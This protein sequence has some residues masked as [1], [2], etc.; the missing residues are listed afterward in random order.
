MTEEPGGTRYLEGA[1]SRAGVCRYP[2]PRQPEVASPRSQQ[3]RWHRSPGTLWT[4]W[5]SLLTKGIR[6]K[7]TPL[8]QEAPSPRLGSRRQA[9]K[10]TPAPHP[11]SSPSG[12]LWPA[13]WGSD[14]HR[15]K[16]PQMLVG[17]PQWKSQVSNE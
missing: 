3:E 1:S 12:R 4:G 13:L 14:L 15:R 8:S 5:L 9:A 2:F 6:L 17:A 7:S 16:D 11:A 10:P